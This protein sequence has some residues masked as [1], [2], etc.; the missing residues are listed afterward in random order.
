MFSLYWVEEEFWPEG[1]LN[2][3]LRSLCCRSQ[4]EFIIDHL[5]YDDGEDGEN[6]D[7]DL[8]NTDNDGL[9]WF[10]EKSYLLP[11]KRVRLSYLSKT[12]QWS[13]STFWLLSYHR[14]HH[15]YCHHQMILII[16]KPTPLLFIVLSKMPEIMAENKTSEHTNLW[17]T[18]KALFSTVTATHHNL[19]CPHIPALGGVPWTAWSRREDVSEG[20]GGR[21]SP[22]SARP[23]TQRHI[24]TT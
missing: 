18:K 4:P 24:T 7:D 15:Y 20:G 10:Y 2:R 6:D 1:F 5:H 23:G 3:S 19:V 9:L 16:S 22:S 11:I 8:D 21:T 14:I 13:L 12:G 17:R